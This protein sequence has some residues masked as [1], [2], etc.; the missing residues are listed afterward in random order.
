MAGFTSSAIAACLLLAA[1]LHQ[2]SPTA[3]LAILDV[4]GGKIGQEVKNSNGSSD[5]GP[6]QINTIWLPQLAQM[7]HTDEQTAKRW[8]KDDPCVNFQVGAWIL[9]DRLKNN[10][11]TVDA[12]AQYHS[13]TPKYRDRYAQKIKKSLEKML[14]KSQQTSYPNAPTPAHKPSLLINT[15]P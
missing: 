2:V 6:M 10:P 11:A 7:W 5:L 9:K 3:M 8:I 4:E 1:E 14:L 12:V 15:T 13:Y